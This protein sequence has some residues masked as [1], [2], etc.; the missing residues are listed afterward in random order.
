MPPNAAIEGIRR[1][2]E[3]IETDRRTIA[4]ERAILDAWEKSLAREERAMRR[5]LEAVDETGQTRLINPITQRPYVPMAA[6]EHRGEVLEAF[7]KHGPAHD[8]CIPQIELERITGMSSGT[9]SRAVRDLEAE[10]RLWRAGRT[11]KRSPIWTDVRPEGV[12]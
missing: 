10:G 5:A 2:Q 3:A 11:S 12:T 8:R 1:H 7:E 6:P 4:H 9:V